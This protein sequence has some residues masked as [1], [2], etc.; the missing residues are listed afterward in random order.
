MD[1]RGEGPQ[2][3]C[4]RMTTLT[5]MPLFLLFHDIRMCMIPGDIKD[6]PISVFRH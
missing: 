1:S 4:C 2:M 5:E 3:L 6:F